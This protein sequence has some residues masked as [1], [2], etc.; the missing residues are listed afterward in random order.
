M[1]DAQAAKGAGLKCVIT[2]ESGLRKKED[3]AGFNV[4]FF[5]QDLTHLSR[6]LTGF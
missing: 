2:L 4:D 1:I 5:I 3:F 6:S